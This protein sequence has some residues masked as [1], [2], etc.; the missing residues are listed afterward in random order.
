MFK[1]GDKVWP[2]QSNKEIEP[3]AFYFPGIIKKIGIDGI[4]W[5][6]WNNDDELYD[7][8]M[9]SLER[10]FVIDEPNDILKELLDK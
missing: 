1:V 6:K 7:W 2:I 4:L 8:D 5:I 3:D 9:R 10:L